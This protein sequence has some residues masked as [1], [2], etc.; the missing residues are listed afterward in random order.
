MNGLVN[1]V[2][3][4]KL[5]PPVG[6]EDGVEKFSEALLGEASEDVWWYRSCPFP[7][8]L[9]CSCR[10]TLMMVVGKSI[11][12]IRSALSS[13]ALRFFLCSRRHKRARRAFRGV[14]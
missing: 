9:S 14:L 6:G 2:G 7:F 3:V 13:S 5:V 8:S 11:K 4:F 10:M 1:A 12:L